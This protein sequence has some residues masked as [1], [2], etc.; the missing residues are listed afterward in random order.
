MRKIYWIQQ[1]NKQLYKNEF[2]ACDFL[3]W[4]SEQITPILVQNFI[5]LIYLIYLLYL[6]GSSFINLFSDQ[7][8]LDRSYFWWINT[9]RNDN[10]DCDI[11]KIE[12]ADCQTTSEY[13]ESFYSMF[14]SSLYWIQLG[15]ECLNTRNNASLFNMSYFGK[16]YL[17]GPDSTNACEW[18][19]S[20]NMD[21]HPGIYFNC[22]LA[23]SCIQVCPSFVNALIE[24]IF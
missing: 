24:L 7:G 8:Q 10:Y 17:T 11:V 13:C 4:A 20:N 12:C 6:I 23:C 2:W 16:F 9:G 19:F 22:N 14:H 15:E 18:I 3:L 1:V 21:K 5:F